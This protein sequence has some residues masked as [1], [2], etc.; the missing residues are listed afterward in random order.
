M[1]AADG[2]RSD[3]STGESTATGQFSSRYHWHSYHT[4]VS[5]PPSV[6]IPSFAD[7]TIHP[8]LFTIRIVSILKL[9]SKFF[10]SFTESTAILT[11]S[12]PFLLFPSPYMPGLSPLSLAFQCVADCIGM[13]CSL[14]R[15]EYNR[16][17]NEVLFFNGNP[18]RNER[19]SQPCRYIVDLIHRP[20]SLLAASTAAAVQYQTI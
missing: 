5:A 4:A 12:I 11:L 9:F 8:H 20:G 19:P 14:V 6:A 13:S 10:P 18:S 1:A 17:W 7:F 2:A 3:R 16:A 15:G